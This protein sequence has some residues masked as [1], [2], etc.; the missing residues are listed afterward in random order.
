MML[1]SG[2]KNGGALRGAKI[3]LKVS[4]L[5]RKY[6]ISAYIYLVGMNNI[7]WIF[8]GPLNGSE[9][10]EL[11]KCGLASWKLHVFPIGAT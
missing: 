9:V 7:Q 8:P 11:Q 1:L 6:V 2:V 10:V 4:E 3:S 5:W